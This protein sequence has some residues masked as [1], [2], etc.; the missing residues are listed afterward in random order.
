MVIIRKGAASAKPWAGSA[1]QDIW[2]M[3]GD[4]GEQTLNVFA[5]AMAEKADTVA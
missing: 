1:A 4:E 3:L 5:M 2:T